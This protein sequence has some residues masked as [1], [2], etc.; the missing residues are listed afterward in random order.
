MKK[1]YRVIYGK[2]RQSRNPKISYI[3][4]ETLVFSIICSMCENEDEKIFKEV[5]SMEILKIIGLIENT[6]LL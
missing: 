4:E 2:Y 3:F 6:Q 5:K 1:L